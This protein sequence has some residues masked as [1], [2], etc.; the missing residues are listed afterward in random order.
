MTQKNHECNWD[1][2]LNKHTFAGKGMFLK[3]L[4]HTVAQRVG[5]GEG[6]TTDRGDQVGGSRQSFHCRGWG[7]PDAKVSAHPGIHTTVQVPPCRWRWSSQMKTGGQQPVSFLSPREAQQGTQ[8]TASVGNWHISPLGREVRGHHRLWNL[9]TP[10]NNLPLRP[11]ETW[12]LW[13]K[14]HSPNRPAAARAAAPEEAAGEA[15]HREDTDGQHRLH[16]LLRALRL[17][18]GWASPRP[19]RPGSAGP[20]GPRLREGKGCDLQEPAPGPSAARPRSRAC[21]SQSGPSPR[22]VSSPQKRSTWTSRA[23]T[24]SRAT[25]TGA[26]AAWATRTSGGACKAWAVTR[27]T[28]APAPRE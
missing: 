3:L 23:Q 17:G 9:P 21:L 26:A 19:P 13:Q 5:V 14:S 22:S 2:Y 18:Q 25:W 12:R 24:I 28:P 20:R 1:A 11:A 7:G 15:G 10:F 27:A 4:S 16:R 8:Q 6:V